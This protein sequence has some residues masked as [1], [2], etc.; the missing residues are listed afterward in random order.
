[1]TLTRSGFIIEQIS[2]PS[3]IERALAIRHAV[4]VEEQGVPL[5]MEIDEHDYANAIHF[6][7]RLQGQPVATARLCLMDGVAK[8]QR[9]AVLI[10][11]RGGGHGA[12]LVAHL[13]AYAKTN[14]LAPVIALDSQTHATG[15]YE[16]LGF[17]TTG[18]PFDDA[19]I[20]H[21]RMEMTI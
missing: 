12:A 21:I 11:A 9:V 17:A 3:E 10:E 19:G 20:M 8:I 2:E 14:R 6:L 4:F 5:N 16:R 7:G 15:F 1:M 18:E 13:V